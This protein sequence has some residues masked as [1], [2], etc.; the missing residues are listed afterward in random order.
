M[1][2]EITYLTTLSVSR[3]YSTSH[4]MIN[5]YVAVSGMRICSG[6]RSTKRHLVTAP[7]SQQESHMT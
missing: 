4:N 1:N 3:L 5:E 7:F 6:T 2:K